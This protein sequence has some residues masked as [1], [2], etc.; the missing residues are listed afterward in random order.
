M[1]PDGGVLF[2]DPTTTYDHCSP[3]PTGTYSLTT[4]SG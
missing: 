2:N 3:Q 1:L 4:A